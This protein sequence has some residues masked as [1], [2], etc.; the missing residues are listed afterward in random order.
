MVRNRLGRAALVVL[1]G[2]AATAV[3]LVVAAHPA[4]ATSECVQASQTEKRLPPLHLLAG[5]PTGTVHEPYSGQFEAAGGTPPYAFE[6]AAGHLPPG[7]TMDGNGV[8]SGTP[9]EAGNYPVTVVVNDAAEHT[10][11]R[12]YTVIIN[13]QPPNGPLTITT[14]TLPNGRVERFYDTEIQ[15]TGGTPGKVFQLLAGHLPPGLRLESDGDL[16]GCPTGNFTSP[17]TSKFTVGV[18][19][20]AGDSTSKVFLVTIRPYSSGEGCRGV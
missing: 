19:D 20:N 15:A 1:T 14:D 18:T 11:C 5:I 7:I 12:Q 16:F 17:Q 6:I 9:T 13:P 3:P 4:A 8:L 10:A 2:W